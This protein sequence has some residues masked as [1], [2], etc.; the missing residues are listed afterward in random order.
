MNISESSRWSNA[1]F[2]ARVRQE[3]SNR[4]NELSDLQPL[5]DAKSCKTIHISSGSP[6]F[7]ILGGTFES[8]DFSNANLSIR[9]NGCK[10][11]KL[12]FMN[13]RIAKSQFINSQIADCDF[14][15][16]T[17]Q[18]SLDD[19]SMHKCLFREARFSGTLS[20]RCGGRR[21]KFEQCDFSCCQFMNV[22]FRAATFADC[23]FQGAK[24]VS[25]DLTGTH[26]IG[27]RPEGS[28]IDPSN[29]IDLL[30]RDE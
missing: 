26:W 6:Y 12:L 22:E 4:I 16:A 8:V 5:V 18:A 19:C 15:G 17:I 30:L 13:A 7:E 2:A 24:F 29:V 20:K 28:Q 10:I 21:I 23:T 11:A 1:A 25:C 14:S 9:F 3:L 27:N